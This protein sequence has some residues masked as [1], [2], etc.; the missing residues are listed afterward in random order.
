M[1]ACVHVC[2]NLAGVLGCALADEET[3]GEFIP[4]WLNGNPSLTFA[5]HIFGSC[6]EKSLLEVEKLCTCSMCVCVS[7]AGHTDGAAQ[8]YLRIYNA[9]DK[10]VALTRSTIK[11]PTALSDLDKLQKILEGSGDDNDDDDDDPA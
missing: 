9:L 6:K 1:C 3:V 4:P 7:D 8:E 10:L 11:D 5:A 2:R